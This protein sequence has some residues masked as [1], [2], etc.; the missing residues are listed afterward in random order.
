MDEIEFRDGRY[1]VKLLLNP[2][3][4]DNYMLA[5]RRV[6]SVKDRLRKNAD[7]LKEYDKIIKAQ[8]EE[9]IV[10]MINDEDKSSV[11]M[12]TYISHREVVTYLS[13]REVIREEKK[14]KKLRI[15]YDASA[16]GSNGVSLNSCLYKGPCLSPLLY[17]LFLKYRVHKIALTALITFQT[18]NIWFIVFP[19][20]RNR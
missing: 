15:V 1:E 7:T 12:V 6:K 17:D 2:V 8:L 18:S 3:I 14:S 11:V 20:Q 16:K 5:V 4:E 13:H 10:E 19:A 9:G